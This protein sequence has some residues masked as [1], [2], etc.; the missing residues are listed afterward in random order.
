MKR[1]RL[2]LINLKYNMKPLNFAKIFGTFDI[3][4]YSIHLVV[5]DLDVFHGESEKGREF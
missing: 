4:Q 2:T 3:N 5:H 1:G